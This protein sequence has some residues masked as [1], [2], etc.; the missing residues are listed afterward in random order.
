MF[1]AAFTSAR[2]RTPT[3]ETLEGEIR[4]QPFCA[5]EGKC[6]GGDARDGGVPV[7]AGEGEH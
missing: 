4:G 7:G 3:C 1:L 6:C 2:R 5:V